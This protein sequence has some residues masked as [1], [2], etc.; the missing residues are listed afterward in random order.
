MEIYNSIKHFIDVNIYSSLI[1][2]LLFLI[3][4]EYFFKNRFK[5]KQVI[6]LIRWFLISYFL[7]GIVRYSM[8]YIFFP[9]E[10][11]FTDRAIGPY[12]WSFWLMFTA[13][14]VFPFTLFYKKLATK[15]LYLIVILFLMKIGW[16]FEQFVI[17]IASFQRDHEE[18]TH[19][20][21]LFTSWTVIILIQI[22]QAFIITIILLGAFEIIARRKQNTTDD[23]S[24]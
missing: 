9:E 8:G 11:A 22:T 19:K 15:P 24:I 18:T 10:F 14:V 16:Y 23:T 5:T 21:D 2:L 3:L 6:N 17:M 13:A 4:I 7:V 20:F 1:P 12:Y